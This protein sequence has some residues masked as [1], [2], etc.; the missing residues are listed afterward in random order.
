MNADGP[1][2]G[3]HKMMNRWFSLLLFLPVVT[4]LGQ[5]APAAAPEPLGTALPPQAVETAPEAGAPGN[6]LDRKIVRTANLELRVDNLESTLAQARSIAT[7]AGGLVSSSSTFVENG[8]PV[9][10]LTLQVPTEVYD[11][12]LQQLRGLSA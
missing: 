6:L 11:S 5:C 10:V 2:P 1:T 3:R 8:F 9:A 12:V 7:G 4:I